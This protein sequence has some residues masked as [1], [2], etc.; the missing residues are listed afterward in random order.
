MCCPYKLGHNNVSRDVSFW[1]HFASA[2]DG[3]EEGEF[4][5]VFEVGSYGDAVGEARYLYT[6]GLGES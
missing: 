4:V 3:F 2:F 1:L 6:E 5:G